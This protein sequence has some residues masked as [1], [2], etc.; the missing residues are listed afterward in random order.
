MGP[1]ACCA[2]L[3]ESGAAASLTSALAYEANPVG[4]YLIFYRIGSGTVRIVSVLHGMRN[5]PAVLRNQ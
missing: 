2:G 3:L 4:H 1:S 5:I